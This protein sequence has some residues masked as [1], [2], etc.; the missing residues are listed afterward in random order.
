MDR[1]SWWT[2]HI[3][4]YEVILSYRHVNGSDNYDL[5]PV[6]FFGCQTPNATICAMCP[7]GWLIAI[8]I[9]VKHPTKKEFDQ[10]D[11]WTICWPPAP[12]TVSPFIFPPSIFQSATVYIFVIAFGLSSWHV[13]WLIPPLGN[14][15][16]LLTWS[17]C[18]QYR[19]IFCSHCFGFSWFQVF[20]NEEK[21]TSTVDKFSKLLNRKIAGATST[22][23]HSSTQAKFGSY[24]TV[25]DTQFRKLSWMASDTLRRC[26]LF[27]GFEADLQVIITS[28]YC[29]QALDKFNK[30]LRSLIR[31]A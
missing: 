1:V 21:K 3:Y 9:H 26:P 13:F 19:Q 24:S 2:S 20:P 10:L 27:T 8:R 31:L 22:S 29:R 23:T 5:P 30:T 7:N 25:T 6:K 11:L 16:Y 14:T 18:S 15:D 12:S 28:R 17:Q 4:V